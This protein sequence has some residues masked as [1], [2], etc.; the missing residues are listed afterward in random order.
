M[1]PQFT[2]INTYDTQA[3]GDAADLGVMA[4]PHSADV[5]KSG[6]IAYSNA[7][8]M[9]T[10]DPAEQEAAKEFLR[11]VLKPGNYGRFLNM[12]PGL[13]LPVTEAG[14]ADETF[15]NDPLAVK[16]QSQIET[17]VENAKS[18]RLFG[19]TNGNTFPSI[20]AISAQNL[21]AQTLQKVVIDGMS[22]ADAVAEGQ[23][24]MEEAVAQ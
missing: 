16:Y 24:L 7:V 10:E 13:F 15:W 1:I 9:L 3:E 6:T 22:P 4:V 14:A 12:E 23:K 5:E 21:L 11:F 20:A 2:V 19:F 8:M 18:G 17:M